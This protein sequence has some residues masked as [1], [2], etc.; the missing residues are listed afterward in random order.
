MSFE[1]ISLKGRA[2]RYLAMRE[3]SRAELERKLAPHEEVPGELAQ[4]LD[5]LQARG[6]IDEQRVIE[7]L[8]YRRASRLGVGRLRQEL[9][10]KGL[11]GEAVQQALAGLR[12]TELARARAVW[13]K[14]F[15]RVPTEATERA[16]QTRFLMARGF[17]SEVVRQVLSGRGVEED[18]SAGSDE[19]DLD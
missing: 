2:L 16:R 17:S 11:Q 15:D 6:F 13:G 8:L 12:D 18:G 4:A 19:T 14:R 5:E 3:H 7:S 1:K 9:Q 10:A